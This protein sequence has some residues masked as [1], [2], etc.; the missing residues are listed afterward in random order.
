MG[1]GIVLM[2]DLGNIS[3]MELDVL[4]ELGSIGAGHAA[5]SLS[6]LFDREVNIA[7]PK[8]RVVEIKN[9][10]CEL[11]SDIVAGVII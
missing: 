5:T 3:E 4:N 11:I 6:L 10:H 8:I 9:I 7:V 2:I 1:S